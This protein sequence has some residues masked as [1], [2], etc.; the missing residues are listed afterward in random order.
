MLLKINSV[1]KKIP[2]SKNYFERLSESNVFYKILK[3]EGDIVWCNRF[4]N[5]V[6][7]KNMINIQ[8]SL[9]NLQDDK[10]YELSP[11]T[12]LVL[13]I[14]QDQDTKEVK[15]TYKYN[16]PEE[17]LADLQHS[18]FE[19]APQAKDGVVMIT[20]PNLATKF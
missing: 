2:K 8:E 19:F 5:G 1:I 14:F 13:T 10:E 15:H 6:L 12:F 4:Q 17:A 20:D 18:S 11:Y 3:I 7:E 9:K 16:S